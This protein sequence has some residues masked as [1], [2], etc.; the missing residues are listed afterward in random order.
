[1]ASTCR[2]KFRCGAPAV[3]AE[4]VAK[5]GRSGAAVV[6]GSARW[7]LRIPSASW[8]RPA[9]ADA[10]AVSSHLHLLWVLQ[11]VW[12]AVGVLL[13]VST[14]MLA[15]GAAAIGW[16]TQGDEVAAAVTAIAFLICAL[17]LLAAGAVNTWA[18]N[19]LKRRQPAGRLATLALAVPNLFI[20]PFGTALGIYAFWVLLH[21][22]A[23][24]QFEPARSRPGYRADRPNG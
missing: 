20:L 12:G 6:G 16:T 17:L 7:S 4:A 5:S 23:R 9:C 11:R 14:L 21:N 22:E 15:A 1:M 13:G 18:G 3:V 10:I 2:S 24:L 19:A 8:F